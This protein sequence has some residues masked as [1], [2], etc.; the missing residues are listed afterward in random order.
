MPIPVRRWIL[1]ACLAGSGLCAAVAGAQ[2]SDARRVGPQPDGSILVPTHQVLRPAGWQVE[3]FG[4][5]TAVA[6]HPSGRWLAVKSFREVLL[7]AVERRTIRQTLSMGRAGASWTGLAWSRDGKTLFLTDTRNRLARAA[8]AKQ[9][10]TWLKPV[11]F[12]GPG[13]RGRCG[14]AGLAL[15]DDGSRA[16][17]CLSRNNTLAVVDLATGQYDEIAVGVAPY[18]V[19]LGPDRKAYVSNWG[20][21]R[22]RKGERSAPSSGTET[23]VDERGIASSGTVSVVDLALRRERKQVETGLHPSGLALSPDRKRLFVAC[24][25]SDAISVIDTASDT[26]VERLSARPDP[27][28]PFGSA[29]NAIAVSSD[30]A[31][32]YVANGGNNAIAVIRLSRRA[33]PDGQGPEASRIAGQ[34]PTAWYPGDVVLDPRRRLLCVANVKGVGSRTPRTSRKGF[35]SHDHRGSISIIPLPDEKALEMHT[36]TVGRN[37]AIGYARRSLLA[38]DSDRTPVP[39]PDRHGEPSL[40]KHVVY[41]IKENR[42]YDQ[43]LGDMPEGNGDPS[44]VHFGEEATPNHHAL[45]RAFTLFDNFYCSGTLSADGHQWTDSAYVTDYLEK[46]FGG[47]VRSYP[48][49]G[50]DPLAFASSGFLWDNALRHGLSFRTY[51]EFVKAIIEPGG[52]TFKDCYD[53][54]V[55]GEGRIKIRAVSPIKSLNPYVCKKTIGFPNIVPDVYRADVFIRELGAFEKNGGFPNLC[56]LL[57]P[58]DHTAGTRPGYPTPRAAVADNDLALGRI[59]EAISRSRY[60]KETCIFVVQDDPQAG[61]DHVDGHRTVALVV[62]PYTRRRFVDST[63]YTQPG[64]VKTIELILGLPPMNVND[65]SATPMR[66]CFTDRPDFTPYEARPNRIPLDRLNPKK[67]ALAGPALHWAKASEA[68]PLD[69]VDRADEDTLN[70]ILWHYCKGYDTPYPTRPGIKEGATGSGDVRR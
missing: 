31:T 61:V 69:D 25:N 11:V 48:Y 28:L 12:K 49:W 36:R 47:W 50:S 18:A 29:P 46:S 3:F 38:A 16:C 1:I 32:L 39:V 66:A 10:L 70:R 7:I 20:G 56:M 68:L 54:F 23:L 14:A 13:G 58:N 27:D 57:L 6:L 15:S 64:M 37:N 40:F 41:I 19:V 59:V 53:D 60:W 26:E 45:A 8:L 33:R 42:T 21:R 22:P 65:L 55:S 24:A 2:E 30:G 43:V 52:V 35:N 17:V 51:G 63:R 9:T 4:R 62:S 44:L 67:K 34:I 5:P